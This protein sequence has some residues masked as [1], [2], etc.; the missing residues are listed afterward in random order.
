MELKIIMLS[1]RSHTQKGKYCVFSLLCMKVDGRLFTKRKRPVGGKRA[2]ES[3]M[4]KYDQCKLYVN[5]KHHNR[6]HCF[7]IK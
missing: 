7:L 4:G 6:T 3:D 1:E 5:I 2:Q